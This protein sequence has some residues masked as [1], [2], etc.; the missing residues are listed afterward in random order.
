MEFYF[1]E[2]DE[3]FDSNTSQRFHVVKECEISGYAGHSKMF[4]I[5][6]TNG[7]EVSFQINLRWE[8]EAKSF[9]ENISRPDIVVKYFSGYLLSLGTYFY[10]F[11]SVF[12]LYLLNNPITRR[13]GKK[14][15]L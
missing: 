14:I 4:S 5:N 15:K 12:Y 10:R 7:H 9:T 6:D 11:Y 1:K 13:E 2:G 3:D 8:L